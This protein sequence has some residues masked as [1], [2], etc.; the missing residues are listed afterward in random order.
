MLSN[1]L[2]FIVSPKRVEVRL[3]EVKPLAWH[4]TRKSSGRIQPL[5][6]KS[7]RKAAT[8][9]GAACKP[10]FT[11]KG[12]LPPFAFLTWSVLFILDTNWT[13]HQ[14][15]DQLVTGIQKSRASTGTSQSLRYES[16]T[17]E[18]G[19][20]FKIDRGG[21]NRLILAWLCLKDWACHT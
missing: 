9:K 4:E 13:P 12:H 2:L 14:W 6:A 16:R 17:S 11:R 1:Q 8:R 3:S 21:T 20:A 5:R 18:S 7:Q 15:G 10:K 19:G